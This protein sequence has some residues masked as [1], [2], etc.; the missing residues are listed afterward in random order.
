MLRELIIVAFISEGVEPQHRGGCHRN[1]L[2]AGA[3][4]ME[5]LRT[6][7]FGRF[8]WLL[9]LFGPPRNSFG[10][11]LRVFFPASGE[12]FKPASSRALCSP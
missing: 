11:M 1:S 5:R 7:V 3:G 10:A 2:Q 9:E 12:E 8:S 4:V 6:L